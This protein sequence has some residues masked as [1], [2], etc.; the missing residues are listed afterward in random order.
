MP[1]FQCLTGISA[2][3]EVGAQTDQSTDLALVWSFLIMIDKHK[4]N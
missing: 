4:S 2:L 3:A 1:F